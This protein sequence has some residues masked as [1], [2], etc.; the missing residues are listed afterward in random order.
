MKSYNPEYRRAYNREYHSKYYQLNYKSL[1]N[2]KTLWTKIL[3]REEKIYHVN[4][5]QN[6][7]GRSWSHDPK[8][9]RGV[10]ENNSF[11][12]HLRG[13]IDVL[14]RCGDIPEWAELAVL[15]MRGEIQT[16]CVIFF[17]KIHGMLYYIFMSHHWGENQDRRAS[18]WSRENHE[19]RASQLRWENQ[20]DWASHSRWKN[21]VRRASH[22]RWE[23]QVWWAQSRN[24]YFF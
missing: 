17:K 5:N 13:G 1:L 21:H 15:S 24:L 12:V 8:G 10:L 20:R 23:N 22:E 16:G 6:K 19:W 11:D 4:I 9:T 14:R 3:N 7:A 18:Q 2:R